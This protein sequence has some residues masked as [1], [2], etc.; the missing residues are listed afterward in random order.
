MSAGFILKKK[1]WDFT[2]KGE[3]L[4]TLPTNKDNIENIVEKVKNAFL[5]QDEPIKPDDIFEHILIE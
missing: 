5:F 1:I 3:L 2:K 4:C